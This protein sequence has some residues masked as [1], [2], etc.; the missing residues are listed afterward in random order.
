MA[1]DVYYSALHWAKKA[2]ASAKLAADLAQTEG[3]VI[4]LGFDGSIQDGQLVFKHAPGGVEVPYQLVDDVEYELDLAYNGD[5][6]SLTT[7]TV[8]NGADNITFVSALHRSSTE[9]AR[10]ADMDAVMRYDAATG[11]RWL[12]KATYKIAP[13]GAKVFLLYPVVAAKDYSD[14]TN[15]ITEIPQDIKLE[16]NNGVLTLKAGSKV[17]VPNGK[18]ADGSLKF[19][20]VMIAYDI[21]NTYTGATFS[22]L[23]FVSPTN[24]LHKP[25]CNMYSGSTAPSG[26]SYMMWYDTEN[27]SVKYTSNGGSTWVGGHSLPVCLQTTTSG[28]GTTSIDQ[29]F[30]GFGYIGSTVFALPNVKGLIPNGRNEDGSLKNNERTTPN[31]ILRTLTD[32]HGGIL[33][34]SNLDNAIGLYAITGFVQDEVNNVN[35]NNQII[36]AKITA[37]SGVITNFTSKLPFRSVDYSDSSWI[38]QQAMPSDKRLSLTLG[39]SGAKYTAPANGYFSLLVK[40]SNTDNFAVIQG[41]SIAS[42]G[43]SPVANGD[44]KLFYPVLKGREVSISYG[45]ADAQNFL[46]FYY[47]E[48]EN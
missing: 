34:G 22:N 35:T 30:N 40:G 29:V 41:A 18:N 37:S 14:K 15:C 3:K 28:S 2:E 8:K 9:P 42:Q 43:W 38:A 24:T 12:F 48:G 20:V 23:V 27:N 4:Q 16:L 46:V 45:K 36:I 7:M 21:S 10:V 26:E 19:D 32:Q 11:Y 17:Y 47:A 31:I 1:N 13:N 44:I 33:V 39:A 25:N 5:L 6:D